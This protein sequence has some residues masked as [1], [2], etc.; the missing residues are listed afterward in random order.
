MAVPKLRFFE[1]SDEWN[2]FNLEEIATFSKGNGYS[3]NDLVESG[4]PVILYGRLYTKYETVISAV[5]TYVIKKDNSVI[6]VGHEVII[7]ASGESAE[8]ISRASVV[9]K[10]GILLGGDLNIVVPDNSIEP[11]FLALTISNGKQQKELSKRAQGKSIV[12]LHNSDLKKVCV[13]APTIGEQKKIAKLFAVLDKKIALQRRKVELLKDNRAGML[14]RLFAL[15]KVEDGEKKLFGEC[16]S[17]L[18]TNSLSRENLQSVGSLQNIH[19]GDIHMLFP[20]LL[21]CQTQS[22]PAIFHQ[23]DI[24]KYNTGDYLCKDGDIV[25][26]DAS[27]DY[28]DVG[29][30]IELKNVRSPLVCGLHTILARPHKGLFASGYCGYMM[31]SPVVRKQIKILASGA[32]VLGISK[33]NLSIVNIPVPSLEIQNQI[34]NTMQ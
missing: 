9:D 10:S 1:F 22:I 20:T 23:L 5:D 25:V 15:E 16:V 18:S 7:P 8:D 17:Y 14:A 21:D 6:S 3:K 33:S 19:Y 11:I 34:S 24:D 26:A 31:A 28:D 13:I 27:E 32:K 4:V 12:H 29:K 30:A 2:S